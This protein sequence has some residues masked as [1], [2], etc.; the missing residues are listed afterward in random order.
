MIFH[1][2]SLELGIRKRVTLASDFILV[3]VPNLRSPHYILLHCYPFVSQAHSFSISF[4]LNLRPG[5][6]K[7]QAFILP[8]EN[9]LT[10][11]YAHLLRYRAL[12]LCSH[13]STTLHTPALYT[14]T[15]SSVLVVSFNTLLEKALV[16]I[17]V[18]EHCLAMSLNLLLFIFSRPLLLTC[19]LVKFASQSFSGAKF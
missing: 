2:S 7:Y 1:E 9:Q 4:L 6:F 16:R 17:P 14:C 10:L 5:L 19:L 12:N 8:N 3:K 15:I 13:H 18:C 11:I